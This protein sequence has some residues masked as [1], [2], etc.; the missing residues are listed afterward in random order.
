WHLS[1]TADLNSPL[2][3]GGW[4][5]F[6]GYFGAAVQNYTNWTKIVNGF[7]HNTSTYST[8]EQANDAISFIQSKGTNRWFV[9]LAF[10]AP[11]GP[12]HKPPTNLLF[13]PAYIALPGTTNDI[14]TNGRAYQEAMTQ[15]LDT[16]IGRLLTY[17]PSNTDIIFLG[18]NGT[19]IS[20][21]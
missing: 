9:W 18:D 8:T 7:S 6:A 11:H 13:T 21:Q 12:I 1:S 15:A 14:S 2:T 10:N 19:E 17:V 3:T 20:Y 16:E 5:N 4:T